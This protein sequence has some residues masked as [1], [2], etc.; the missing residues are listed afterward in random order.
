MKKIEK[1]IEFVA[2]CI[3]MFAAGVFGYLGGIRHARNV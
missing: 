1:I 2:V 3:G